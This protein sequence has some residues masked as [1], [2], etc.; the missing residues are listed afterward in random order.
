LI[1]ASREPV[2]GQACDTVDVARGEVNKGVLVSWPLGAWHPRRSYVF[3]AVNDD[4]HVVVPDVVDQFEVLPVRR[5]LDDLHCSI[6]K[7]DT[8]RL[9]CAE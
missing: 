2:N 3:V 9:R 8:L 5:F 7:K 6:G 1:P 4:A